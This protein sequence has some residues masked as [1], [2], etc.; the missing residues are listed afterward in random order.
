VRRAP[1]ARSR[2][3][4]GT[5]ES[6]GRKR[7]REWRA[8]IERFESRDAV[9][10]VVGLGYVGLPVAVSF[11]EAGFEVVG[12]DL[13][14]DKVQALSEGHS[15]LADVP[16]EV[17]ADLRASGKLRVTTS[18][19]D[20]RQADAVLICLPTPLQDGTPDL[21]FITAAGGSVA[22]VL[23]PG[24]LVVLEST[25]YPGTTEE[26]LQPLLESAGLKA[27]KDFL[28][29]YSPERIDPGNPIYGF[30][31]I[32]KVVGGASSPAR[33]AA[34]GLYQQV[35]PKVITVSGTR[36]AELA[37]LIEN[38]F[39]HVNIALVNELAVYAHEMG[40]DIWEAIEV[41]ATKPFGYM[42]FW[43]SPGWGGHCIPLDPS[44]LS[45]KVRKE[46]AHD[47]RFVELA[48]TVNSEMPRHVTQRAAA[49]LNDRGKALRG[50]RILGVGVAYKGGTEDTRESA[51]IKVLDSL[52]SRG[53]KVSFYDPLVPEI[54]VGNH[55]LCSTSLATRTLRKQDLVIVFVPQEGVDYNLIIKESP[56]VFDCC[57][58][59]KKKNARLVRL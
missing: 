20:L 37:K 22:K 31:D 17:V 3:N 14:A 30:G 10:A 34:Q 28:L 1:H 19:D 46:R 36:E 11:A 24:T 52:S 25:T 27:G 55:D 59:L 43:P 9:L 29:A 38:T 51:G 39:R 53:A 57:N 18:Y 47:V 33:S 58:A 45:W 5:S 16:D 56:L 23:C 50:S 15:Y 6:A 35:V 32:P 4:G 2:T 41:A 26:L 42:P 7:A 54:R 12:V 40:I 8:L 21:S 49:L 44:Y 48:Q 13:A